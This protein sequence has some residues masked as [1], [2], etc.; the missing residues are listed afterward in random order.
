M[1][2]AM[3]VCVQFYPFDGEQAS[4]EFVDMNAI[5][6]ASSPDSII[7]RNAIAKAMKDPDKIS[8]I[9]YEEMSGVY[10]FTVSLPTT[11]DDLVKVYCET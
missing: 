7:V 4:V 3:I 11:V 6:S 5:Q 1:G 9:K 8:E 2:L 10:G